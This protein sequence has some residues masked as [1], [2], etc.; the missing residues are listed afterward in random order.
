MKTYRLYKTQLV[1]RPLAE[2]FSFFEKPENLARITP[3]SLGF[4]ILT[5]SLVVMKEGAVFEY[6]VRV[7]GIRM[8]WKSLITDYNPPFSFVDRQVMGPYRFWHHSH[9]FTEVEQGTLIDDEVHY[10]MPFGLIGMVA[11][12]LA[13]KK[14][15]EDI[16]SHR[17]KVITVMFGSEQSPTVQQKAHT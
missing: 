16:F 14:Q 5:P 3:P 2:V 7:M 4:R 1:P 10:A 8:R 6:S 12:R 13:V 9:T 17:S 15:L 11:Q